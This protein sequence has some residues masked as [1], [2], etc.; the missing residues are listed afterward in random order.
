[1][2]VIVTEKKY[3]SRFQQNGQNKSFANIS[4]NYNL[5]S[6]QNQTLSALQD[7]KC[8]HRHIAYI[9]THLHKLLVLKQCKHSINLV[10]YF[11]IKIQSNV[12]PG[13]F[14]TQYKNN[15]IHYDIN[16]VI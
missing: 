14:P 5:Y 12:N 13:L 16:D 9:H 7:K 15:K 6:S 2:Y 10:R 1:M 8:T 4:N 3:I 11:M